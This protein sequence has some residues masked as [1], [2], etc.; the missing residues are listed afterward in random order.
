[1]KTLGLITLV[2]FFVLTGLL[3]TPLHADLSIPPPLDVDEGWG[4]TLTEVYGYTSIESMSYSH[5]IATSVHSMAIA[6]HFMEIDIDYDYGFTNI[7]ENHPE[8]ASRWFGGGLLSGRANED[9]DAVH[10]D[11]DSHFSNDLDLSDLLEGFEYNFQAYTRL[12]AR[13]DDHPNQNDSWTASHSIWI[14]H[15]EP[16]G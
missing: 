14:Q 3:S 11:V 6:N 4:S 10:S 7:I 15:A 1:M 9:D 8:F 2:G 16:E 5:P 13:N 12:N